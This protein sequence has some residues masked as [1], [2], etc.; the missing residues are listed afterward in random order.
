MVL[1]LCLFICKSLE[2]LPVGILYLLSNEV[3]LVP[4]KIKC[5]TEKS[6]F[7]QLKLKF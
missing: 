7:Q 1:F 5:F 3:Q 2:T 6:G 4:E